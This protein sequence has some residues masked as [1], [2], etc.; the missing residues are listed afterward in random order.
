MVQAFWLEGSGAK[1]RP[2]MRDV[3]GELQI[4][5]ARL[6]YG[7]QVLFVHFENAV[8]AREDDDQSALERDGAAAQ[9]GARAARHHRHVRGRR[10]PHDLGNL[11]RVLRENDCRGRALADA[12]VI[13]VEH[14]VFGRVEHG[15]VPGDPAQLFDE[16]VGQ[17]KKASV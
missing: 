10:Q 5:H 1:Y 12:G 3:L 13:L 8:H 17:H 4:D 15:V 11:L 9:S 7:A 14:D 6:H 16:P 2:E